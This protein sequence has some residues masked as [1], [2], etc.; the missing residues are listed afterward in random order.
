VDLVVADVALRAGLFRSPAGHPLVGD[1]HSA[2]VI[3]AIV[4]TL[5]PSIVLPRLLRPGPT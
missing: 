2:V 4:T 3:M 1:I 5:A